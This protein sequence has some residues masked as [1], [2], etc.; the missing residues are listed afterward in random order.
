M[1]HGDEENT[2]KNRAM[3]CFKKKLSWSVLSQDHKKKYFALCFFFSKHTDLHR[4][5]SPVNESLPPPPGVIMSD[6]GEEYDFVNDDD[7]GE[8]DDFD[9]ALFQNDWSD[10]KYTMAQSVQKFDL[11]AD[12]T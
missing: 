10:D 2:K 1:V 5:F 11:T 8:D 7:V 4:H 6:G 3:A 12:H 9:D